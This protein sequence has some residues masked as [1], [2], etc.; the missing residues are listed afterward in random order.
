[1]GPTLHFLF[2]S[3]T[4]ILRRYSLCVCSCV[5]SAPDD[6]DDAKR[7][8]TVNFPLK[9]SYN[10]AR[11]EKRPRDAIVN[12]EKKDKNGEEALFMPMYYIQYC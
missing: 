3:T 6:D 8:D 5:C 1:M 2:S 10:Y 7:D 11:L 4:S 12:T 9:L